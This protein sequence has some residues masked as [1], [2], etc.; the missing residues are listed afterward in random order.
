M[1]GCRAGQAPKRPCH[2]WPHHARFLTP[3]LGDQP[4][5]DFDEPAD[6]RDQ[7]VPTEPVILYF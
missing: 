4:G 7:R 5:V 3:A 1:T 6:A 2:S